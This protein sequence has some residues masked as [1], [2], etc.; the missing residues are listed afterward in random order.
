M[1]ATDREIEVWIDLMGDNRRVGT[2]HSTLQRGRNLVRFEYDPSWMQSSVAFALEPRL[3][4]VQGPQYPDGGYA[5]FP[6][7]TDAAPDRWGRYLIA[8][9]EQYAAEQEGR[10]PRAL[11]DIDY[12]VGLSDRHRMGALRFRDPGA[13]T[14]LSASPEPI[15][16]VARLRKL[17]EAA[18]HLESDRETAEDIRL[19]LAP[20]SSLGGARPKAVVVDERGDEWIAKFERAQDPRP[21]PRWEAL[22][23]R[24]AHEARIHTPDIQIIEIDQRGIFLSRRFDRTRNSEGRVP[25]VSAMTLCGKRDGEEASYIEIAQ[26]IRQH[27][28]AVQEDL[29]QLWRR[30]VFNVLVRNTDDHLRNHGFLWSREEGWRLAPAFDMNPT[31][32]EEGAP[33]HALALDDR[34]DRSC[35]MDPVRRS[36]GHFGVSTPAARQIEDDVRQALSRWSEHASSFGLSASECRRMEG[37]LPQSMQRRKPR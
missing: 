16:P 33:V 3:P 1:A 19:L 13:E 9:A 26:A 7:F 37:V 4:L 27:G 18:R 17:Q 11:M 28:G 31:P 21:I 22:T 29:E 6:V 32:P 20:G 34:G 2:L 10:D 14:F 35:S 23:A 36:A 24:L 15:P 30:M 12:L 5:L 25:Y 8:R